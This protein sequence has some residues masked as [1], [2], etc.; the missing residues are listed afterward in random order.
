MAI[1]IT[2]KRKVIVDSA[3]SPIYRKM[4][5]SYT[6]NLYIELIETSPQLNIVDRE[7][8]F[9]YL[10]DATAA[11]ILQNPNFFGFIDDHTDIVEHCHKKGIIAIQSVYPVALAFVKTPAEQ[12]F[13]IAT[14]EGQSLGIPL[15]F[16]GPYLGFMAV[17]KE[18][19][20]VW[21]QKQW[22]K[23]EERDLFFLY[24]QENN[25]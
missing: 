19:R 3:V 2:G 23:M 12:G 4:L 14:G 11:V 10:D 7:I 25:T 8:L 9:K 22:I 17:K 6:A 18:C 20:G 13:D 24:R 1:H 5:R 16:G 21:L 15:S